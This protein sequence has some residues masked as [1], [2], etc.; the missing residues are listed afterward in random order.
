MRRELRD[1]ASAW[2]DGG[3]TYGYP[4]WEKAGQRWR[5]GEISTTLYREYV[6]GYRDRLVLGCDLLDAIDTSTKVADEVRSRVLDSCHERVDALR[7]QQ[8]WLDARIDA[9]SAPS[10]DDAAAEERATKAQAEADAALQD[11]Y[12]DARLATDQAQAELDR[13]G[14]K[15]LSEGAFI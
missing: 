14:L 8:R 15:R 3:G 10:T 5:T 2:A 7:A 11:S 1:L 9:D 4:F 13:V 6:T 12:R